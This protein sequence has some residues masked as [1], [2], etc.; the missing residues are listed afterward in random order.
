[1]LFN[2]FDKIAMFNRNDYFIGK[3]K[4]ALPKEYFMT[5]FFPIGYCLFTLREHLS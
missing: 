2:T 4:Y 3:E 5:T 1:M